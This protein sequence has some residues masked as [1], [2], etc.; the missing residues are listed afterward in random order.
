[1]PLSV[2]ELLARTV[3]KAALTT[4]DFSTGGP[5]GTNAP[6][7][8][9]QAKT[10]IRLLSNEQ[11]LLN[12]V[13]TVMSNAATW[14]ASG[15]DFSAR[16]A[17]P[18]AQ[19]TRL[20]APD[21]VKPSTFPVEIIT[22]LIRAE[23]PVADEVYEDAAAAGDLDDSLTET[24]TSR[25]GFDIEDLLLNGDTSSGDPYLALL[26]GWIKLAQ[27]S[28]TNTV[29]ATTYGQDYESIFQ[30]MLTTM[31]QRFKRNLRT[32]GRFWVPPYVEETYRHDLAQRGTSLGDSALQQDIPLKY[33][34]IQIVSVPAM[35][36]ASGSPDTSTILLTNRQNLYA[37]W[38]RKMT[39]ESF[40]DPREGATSFIVT[41][42]PAAAIAVVNASVI[43]TGV[44]VEPV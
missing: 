14:I 17:R 1:M 6:L 9:E 28:G 33:Q 43:A 24:I 25:F 18:G 23:V 37:G 35:A 16:I 15:I 3:S 42:R 21:R 19:A 7:S 12:D 22:K 44:D 2:Q 8:I 31:P 36:T 40:R 26:D 34:G 10:F 38:Q 4:S 41:A 30:R 11:V 20:D 5:G 29:S 13:N 39:F 27:G 32:D